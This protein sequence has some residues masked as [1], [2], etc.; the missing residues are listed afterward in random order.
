MEVVP[1]VYN[2]HTY[3][4]LKNFG[5]NVCII[6]SKIWVSFITKSTLKSSPQ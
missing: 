2:V 3:F 1:P 4:S 6:H 5:K